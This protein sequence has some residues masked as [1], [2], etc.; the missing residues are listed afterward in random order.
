MD[1]TGTVRLML[2][3]VSDGHVASKL[4][5]L[6]QLLRVLA[7]AVAVALWLALRHR[8][9]RPSHGRGL[10]GLWERREASDFGTSSWLNLQGSHKGSAKRRNHGV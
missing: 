8:K 6:R 7:T 4:Q 5:R 3:V 1:T 9:L 2:G 10:N